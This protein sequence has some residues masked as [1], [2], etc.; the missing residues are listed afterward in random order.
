MVSA[1]GWEPTSITNGEDTIIVLDE[2]GTP[3][4]YAPNGIFERG[5]SAEQATEICLD[6]VDEEYNS[7]CAS[8]MLLIESQEVEVEAFFI[9]QYEVSRLDYIRC[10]TYRRCH[11][12][13]LNEA[14][15]LQ[16]LEPLDFPMQYISQHQAAYFCESRGA[17]LP[18]EIEWE[19]AARGTDNLTFPWGDEFDGSVVNFCD[20]NCQNTI[21]NQSWDDGFEELA[22][23]DSMKNGQSW[24]GAYH[25]GG[26]VAEW[27]VSVSD[28]LTGESP[29]AIMGGAYWSSGYST[30][31]WRAIPVGT[32]SGQQFIG[33]RCARSPDEHMQVPID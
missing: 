3:M 4:V 1:Q 9:D 31:P 23:V 20:L 30:V 7:F 16:P 8:D 29:F 27:V 17:R 26:N 2:I 22:P 21:A 19:Y 15:N 5:Y 32:I 24:I 13:N 33:F 14:F 6:L 18:T 25:L 10:M 12:G 11:D 28:A